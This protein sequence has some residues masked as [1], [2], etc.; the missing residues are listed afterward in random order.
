[1]AKIRAD[2]FFR[3][4]P[5]EFIAFADGAEQRIRFKR[6]A[7]QKYRPT[8]AVSPDLAANYTRI[9]REAREI[10]AREAQS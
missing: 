4:R 8:G 10:A 1:V 6:P 9:Y 3:L 5:G 7:H 2:L